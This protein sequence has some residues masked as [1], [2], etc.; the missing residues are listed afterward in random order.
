[1]ID[2]VV[3]RFLGGEITLDQFQREFIPLAWDLNTEVGFTVELLLAEYTNGHR[4]EEDL[5][6]CIRTAFRKRTGI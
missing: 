5:Y 3:S 2:E 4:T 1:M 6:A